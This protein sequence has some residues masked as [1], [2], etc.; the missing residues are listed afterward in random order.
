MSTAAS[1]GVTA[2]AL[3][4]AW[5]E[6]PREPIVDWFLWLAREGLEREPGPVWDSLAVESADIEALVLFPELRRG[7]ADGLIDARVMHPSELEDVEAAPRGSVLE[8]T[9]ERWPPIDDVASA[10]GW[11]ARFGKA[12][13]F[14]S[15]AEPYRAS[16]KIGRNE[17]CPCGSGRKFKKCC[18]A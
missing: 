13:G 8:A 7:Y 6:V 15:T 10:I 5:V 3:L 1:A 9:R 2:L 16:P 18:G 12:A 14:A 17:P 11:W 4:A